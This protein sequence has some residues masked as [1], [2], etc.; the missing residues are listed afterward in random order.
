MSQIE[1]RVAIVTGGA[2]GIGEAIAQRLASDGASVVIADNNQAAAEATAARI[3]AATGK[4]VVAIYCDIGESDSVTAM[5]KQAIE[6]FGAVDI[7]VNNAGIAEFNEPLDT[8]A[9]AW[10]RCMSIDLEGAW[11]CCKVV[12]PGMIERRY[13]TIINIISNHAFSII[14]STFPYPVAKHGLL[15]LT[16]ALAIEY[17]DRGIAI[18]AI[19]PGYVDT[20]IADW[21]FNQS[22]DPAKAR[23]ET[24]ALQ[25]PKRLCKPSEVA[26]V[27]SLLTSDEARFIIGENIVIDGGVS[28][29]MY[30]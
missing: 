30:D 26:A 11:L 17:A 14:K 15:G 29:R 7:L 3:S 18:N 24:E 13:G 28:V 19:S 21:Y 12:L 27:A 23:R 2:Q 4:N 25:P 5:Y 8:D 22:P 6:Q 20:P 9:D 16:R 1:N 10:Q